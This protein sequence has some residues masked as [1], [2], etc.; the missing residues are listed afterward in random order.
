MLNT[1]LNP[2]AGQTEN[3]F[4]KLKVLLID[5]CVFVIVLIVARY[6][7]LSPLYAPFFI[8]EASEAFMQFS[9]Y[10]DAINNGASLY[11]DH[12]KMLSTQE[13]PMSPLLSPITLFMLAVSWIFSLTELVELAY[14]FAVT[15]YAVQILTGFFMYLF[16]KELGLGR[17]AAIVGSIAYSYNYFV[18]TFGVYHGYYRLSALMIMPILFIFLLRLFRQSNNTLFY[19]ALCGF[20]L[21]LT[22]ISNG[23]VKPGIYFIPIL[24]LLAFFEGYREHGPIRTAYLL[25]IIFIIGGCLAMAQIY[26]TYEALSDGI[27]STRSAYIPADPL[28]PYDTLLGFSQNPFSIIMGFLMPNSYYEYFR[29]NP[30]LSVGSTHIWEQRFSF[31]IFIFLLSTIGLF[32]RTKRHLLWGISFIIFMLYLLGA[33][34][35]LWPFFGFISEHAHLRYPTRSAVMIYFLLSI[36]A[37]YGTEILMGRGFKEPFL[38]YSERYKRYLLIF[39]LIVGAGL[40]VTTIAHNYSLLPSIDGAS[41]VTL[42]IARITILLLLYILILT[43]YKA[44]KSYIFNEYFSRQKPAREQSSRILTNKITG[45]AA[46][47]L[48]AILFFLY[49][50]TGFMNAGNAT[51]SV[52]FSVAGLI[53]ESELLVLFLSLAVFFIALKFALGSKPK[54]IIIIPIICFG[55][56][57][58][59]Y[60]ERQGGELSSYYKDKP[61]SVFKR[62]SE[63]QPI[64]ADTERDLY[65][66]FIPRVVRTTMTPELGFSKSHHTYCCRTY[67]DNLRFAFGSIVGP[68]AVEYSRYAYRRDYGHPFWPLY[69]VKYIIDNFDFMPELLPKDNRSFDRLSSKVIRLK[70]PKPVLYLMDSF[71]MIKRDD[72]LKSMQVRIPLDLSNILYLHDQPS[73]PS[74]NAKS[75]GTGEA[76]IKIT[77]WVSGRLEAKVTTDSASFLVFSEVWAPSWTVY[78]DGVRQDL[79]R[80]YGMLQAVQVEGGT[81]DILF[82]YNIFHS[83][84]MRATVAL[85]T[86]ALLFVLFAV[87]R[88]LICGLNKEN[89]P[90]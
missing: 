81:H 89:Q 48:F 1:E 21:G 32:Y 8:D 75:K 62:D 85:S 30:A 68:K 37:A 18:Q 49:I 42:L 47:V 39:I 25:A 16:L 34:T 22:F 72:F 19:T 56:I 27:R 5:L 55:I 86:L 45:K 61:Q 77:K 15:S 83:W 74:T 52:T 17:F 13:M 4:E 35:P 69:N 14:L 33:N 6:Y 24:I 58:G 12:F 26:P 66:T 23:D 51:G 87:G 46:I 57:M 90:I 60:T 38:S 76:K 79:L 3:R 10:V 67:E 73:K 2:Q 20:F 70:D 78:V 59:L 84:K 65:R 88:G 11:W 71:E 53:I 63:F 28:K 31:P 41:G 7:F 80:A 44:A 50:F 64:Y 43:L 9:Y 36:Y 54:Q 82:K 40:I 29:M